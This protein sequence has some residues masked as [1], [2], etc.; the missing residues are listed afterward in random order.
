MQEDDKRFGS[1]RL[2]VAFRGANPEIIGIADLA[3]ER[4]KLLS[5]KDS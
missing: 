2:L 3:L 5:R 4:L 1:I